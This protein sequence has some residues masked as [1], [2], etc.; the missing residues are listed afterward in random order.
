MT[1]NRHWALSRRRFLQTTGDL[2]AAAGTSGLL[3]GC[4]TTTAALDPATI[5]DTPLKERT[6]KFIVGTHIDREYMFHRT[7]RDTLVRDFE[8]IIEAAPV[9]WGVV[10]WTRSRRDYSK[11]DRIRDFADEH[12]LL[13]RGQSL[14]WHQYVPPWLETA[15]GH[16]N[17]GAEWIMS[18]HIRKL[19][20][21][22]AGRMQSWNVVNEA[23]EPADGRG[24]GLRDT[25]LLRTIGP[26]YIDKAFRAAAEADPK[27]RLDY[28]EYGLHWAWQSG[29]DR[30]RHTLKLLERLRARDVPI[31]G[32][33]LQGHLSPDR[34]R[35]FNPRALRSFLGEVTDLGLDIL[36]TELDARDSK[37]TGSIETRDDIVADAYRRYLDVVLDFDAVTQ[38]SVWGF[39]DRVSWLTEHDPRADGGLVRGTPYDKDYRKK[40]AWYAL[41]QA[42]GQS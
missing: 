30:R 6:D 8:L 41:A 21:R 40:P 28:N 11:A 35:S 27:A 13:L 37:L 17:P 42:L 7:Y 1:G 14:I 34:D 10:E 3:P 5:G 31:H 20:G 2:A 38:V 15:L 24:D 19:A 29:A 32:L 39:S 26:D 25:P 4:V 16:K 18:E 23:I 36:V 12:G 22:Y 33:G 9:L